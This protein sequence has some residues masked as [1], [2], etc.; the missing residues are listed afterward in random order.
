MAT[1]KRPAPKKAPPKSTAKK[2]M[3]PKKSSAPAFDKAPA[4]KSQKKGRSTT[5]KVLPYV[6]I[7]FA[8]ILA[9]ATVI[10]RLFGV[11]DGAGA[12]GY[13]ILWLL[14]GFF[15]IGTV[16]LP[17]AL[18]YIG[19]KW[20]LH[21]I[22]WKDSDISSESESYTKA[23]GRLVLQSV[24]TALSVLFFSV[25]FAT[26]ANGDYFDFGSAWSDGAEDLVGGGILG[27]LIS[28]GLVAAFALV[29]TYILVILLLVLFTLLALG[30]TPDYI[31][32]KIRESRA[33]RAEER[34]KEWEEQLAEEE[35][36]LAEEKNNKHNAAAAAAA[37]AATLKATAPRQED[38]PEDNFDDEIPDLIPPDESLVEPE[39]Y[40]GP[41]K[42]AAP[43]QT[44]AAAAPKAPQA[45]TAEVGVDYGDD[46]SLDTSEYDNIDE[47]LGD[48]N[49]S[50]EPKAEIPTE[51]LTLGTLGAE[52]IRSDLSAVAP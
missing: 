41:V 24:M 52:E 30:L 22:N 34:A 5:C 14:G 31:I 27:G 36:R 23:R 19:V 33:V 40:I 32:E 50:E 38:E 39:I 45:P 35:A 3:P 13:G 16:L 21:N 10:V 37:A 29:L 2:S 28:Y 44:P 17:V 43:Q 9:I 42:T 26:I 11:D 25:L 47:I 7:I 6:F 46:S 15:G 48:L 4:Q 1:K 12:L 18:G 51:E 8:L 49:F 20:C